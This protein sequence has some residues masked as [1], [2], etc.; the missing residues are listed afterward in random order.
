MGLS[1]RHLQNSL[2]HQNFF[3]KSKFIGETLVNFTIF[4]IIIFGNC[5]TNL[6]IFHLILFFILISDVRV[7]EFIFVDFVKLNW[8]FGFHYTNTILFYVFETLVHAPKINFRRICNNC[9]S[10][11]Y[12]KILNWI[13]LLESF[14]KNFEKINTPRVFRI[15]NL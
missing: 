1:A 11:P 15:D 8:H 12:R 5:R 7:I 9:K 2:C 6:E 10:F 14:F 3:D 13:V 4:Q